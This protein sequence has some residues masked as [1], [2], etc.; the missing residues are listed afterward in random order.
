MMRSLERHAVILGLLRQQEHVTIEAMAAACDASLQTIRRDLNQLGEDG[1]VVRYHGGARLADHARSATYEV[2]SASHVREKVAAGQLL[3]RFIPDGATLFIAGGST[4]A[5]AAQELRACEGLTIVTNN[6]HA[7][8]TLY[9]K[10]GFDVCVLGGTMRPASGSMI[11]EEAV[12]MI[13]RYSLD[14]AVIGTCGIS[15]D[16]ALLEYDQSLV[17][18]LLAMISNAR[19]TVLVADGSKFGAKGIVR[20]APLSAVNHFV[21]DRAPEGRAADLLARTGVK[22][23]HPANPNLSSQ[24]AA[25]D[26]RE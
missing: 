20:A 13:E 19:R 25:A 3:A 26:G 15:P 8:V 4:L 14:F 9:D 5:L 17:P 2:R 6:L 16:G 11:G 12:R 1:R 21:T 18:P 10:T 24:D 23:H 7:A 22:V